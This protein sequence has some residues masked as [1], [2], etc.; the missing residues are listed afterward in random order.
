MFCKLLKLINGE[1]IVGH[2]ASD[3]SLLNSGY[4]EMK[5][6]VLLTFVK[7]PVDNMMVETLIMQSWMKLANTNLI[8]IPVRSIVL[9]VDVLDKVEDQYKQF[10]LDVF[11][12]E[13]SN[14]PQDIINFANE[15]TQVEYDDE[16]DDDDDGSEPTSVNRPIFH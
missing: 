5:N 16:Y 14:P 8:R 9:A 15:D 1:T 2:T 10:L 6:P 7:M 3:C 11:E 13:R 12:M 4:V